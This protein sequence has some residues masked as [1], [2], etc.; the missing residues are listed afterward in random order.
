MC[1]RTESEPYLGVNPL[2]AAIDMHCVHW[3]GLWRDLVKRVPSDRY[4]REKTLT[5]AEDLGDGVTLTFED[6]SVEDA[7]LVL[8]CDG[9]N[10]MGRLL[11][12]PEVELRY[13][14]YLVWRGILPDSEV[15]D[16]APLADHPRYS[17]VSIKGSFISF[18]I[19]SVEGSTMPGER[20]VNWGGLCPG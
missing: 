4:R 17:C 12:F 9:Y 2:S 13:R 11:L 7:E 15:S 6:G 8:F 14:G 3:G 10:S 20:T 1:K 16:H 18:V 5:A 19:P